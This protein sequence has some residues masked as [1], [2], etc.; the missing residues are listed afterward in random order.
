MQLLG[1]LQNS[2]WPKKHLH[3]HWIKNI[4]VTV[5][6]FF[7]KSLT[8]EMTFF[9]WSKCSFLTCELRAN[10]ETVSLASKSLRHTQSAGEG[11]Y[12]ACSIGLKKQNHEEVH[13]DFYNMCTK[14]LVKEWRGLHLWTW[15]LVF[16]IHPWYKQC[17]CQDAQK[18]SLIMFSFTDFIQKWAQLL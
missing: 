1:S 16:L 13:R 7:W 15:F 3:K 8:P 10:S 14:Q 17:R 5:N 4:C 11:L 12:W 18:M 2:H 9:I 6:T